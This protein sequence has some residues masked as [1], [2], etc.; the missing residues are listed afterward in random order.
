MKQSK[1]ATRV[2]DGGKVVEEKTERGRHHMDTNTNTDD[3]IDHMLSACERNDLDMV[4]ALATDKGEATLPAGFLTACAHNHLE[5][6]KWIHTR[7]PMNVLS[8]DNNA[9]LMALT[10]GSL[11]VLRWLVDDLGVD[12]NAADNIQ[13]VYASMRGHLPVVQWIWDRKGEVT[14]AQKDLALERATTFGKAEVAAWWRSH[15]ANSVTAVALTE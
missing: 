11:D 7:K 10:H 14:Q 12:I 8:P 13:L 15:G 2:G 4:Q 5:L 3:D 6:A 1:W 9:V